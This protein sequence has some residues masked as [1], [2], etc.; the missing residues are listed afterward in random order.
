MTTALSSGDPVDPA[1]AEPFPS[2]T[3]YEQALAEIRAAAAAYYAG[4]DV[5]M[6]DDAYDALLAPDDRGPRRGLHDRRGF[7]HRQ[8]AA[9]RTRR[10]GVRAP[11]QRCGRD[12]ARDRPRLLRAPFVRRLRRAGARR[13]RHALGSHGAA[14][15]A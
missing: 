8:R 15:K 2:R 14:G 5:L 13:R 1:K 9:H 7:P 11:A 4:P 6:D 3:R 10:A 12:T